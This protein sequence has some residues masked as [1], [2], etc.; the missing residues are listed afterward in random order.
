M[1]GMAAQDWRWRRRRALLVQRHGVVPCRRGVGVYTLFEG[2]AVLFR[3]V[4]CAGRTGV[5]VIVSGS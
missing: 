4:R 2:S 5:G 3:G 1:A